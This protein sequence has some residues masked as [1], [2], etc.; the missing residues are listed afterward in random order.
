[1]AWYIDLSGMTL[2]ITPD[3]PASDDDA[4]AAL[5]DLGGTPEIRPHL[6]VCLPVSQAGILRRLPSHITVRTAPDATALWL[7]TRFPA[8][9]NCPATVVRT[10]QDTLL[11]EWDYEST[12]MDATI[13]SDAI[14]AFLAAEIPFVATPD[15]WVLIDTATRTPQVTGR[16]SLNL[17]GF[18]EVVSARPQLIEA[19]PLP[20]LFRLNA[21]RFG[22]PLA[23]RD[24]LTAQTGLVVDPLPSLDVPPPPSSTALELSGHH[25][26]DLED[27]AT[28]LCAYQAQVICW[29]SGLGRRVFALAALDRL[30][31]WPAIIVTAPAYLW[32]WQRHLDLI[33]RSY[34]MNHSDA[35]VHLVT[36]HDL[37]LRRSL[38]AAPAMIFDHLSSDEATAALPAL[39]RLAGHRDTLRI[40]VESAWPEDAAEQV[41]VMEILRPGEFRTD[42]PVAERYPP[43]SYVRAQ[44]HVNFYLSVR[45]LGDDNTDPRPFRRSATRVV[46]GTQAQAIEIDHLIER[47]AGVA[48]HVVLMELLDVV[49]CGPSHQ[50]SP[51]LAAAA[52]I[53]SSEARCGHAVAVVTRS[54][55]AMTLLRQLLRP[56]PVTVVG[57][58][59]TAEPQGGAVHLVRFERTLPDLSGFDHVVVID[60]PWSLASLD[61]SVGPASAAGAGTVTMVHAAGTSDDRL[62]VLAS[63]R[64]ERAAAMDDTAPPTLEEIAYLIAPR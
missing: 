45:N 2:L 10:R 14:L 1:M 30:D 58:D 62:A 25:L 26:A 35:D 60:Y 17:D 15:S 23:A 59:T 9:P 5:V 24:A 48:A 6:G 53:A 22:L 29:E 43:D 4:A 28:A 27:L 8:S 16:V 42:V 64:R 44:E 36:Y 51:K 61:R 31:A 19:V 52:Q 39:R 13:G 40:A 56:L 54:A 46:Q 18:L 32:A 21:V 49:T 12:P 11:L 41:A 63:Q 3:L 34:S 20:G 7:A 50:M 55:R 33:G 47:S 57:P 38:P 37:S